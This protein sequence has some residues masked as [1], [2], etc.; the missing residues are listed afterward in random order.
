M[1]STPTGSWE[2]SKGLYSSICKL[3][4]IHCIYSFENENM[5]TGIEQQFSSYGYFLKGMIVEDYAE[6]LAKSGSVNL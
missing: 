3:V 1:W 5:H 2:Q 6:E 4:F